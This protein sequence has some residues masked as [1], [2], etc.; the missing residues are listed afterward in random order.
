MA[1]KIKVDG[2]L[3]TFEIEFKGR[4]ETVE[5]AFNPNDLDL[6][7]RLMEAQKIIEEK[8]KNVKQFEIGEDGLP[9]ADS[10]IAYVENLNQIVYDAVD[11]AFDNEVSTAIFK[12]CSP[13]GIVN[14]EY[15]I[16]HFLQQITPV[17]EK[18]I[19]NNQKKVNENMN[20]HLAKYVKK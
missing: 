17:I 11:Y 7:K 8:S 16:Q 14:G 2:G 19:K 5:I 6:P 15:F 1:H 9:D 13:Y 10:C 4:N 18:T 3:E 20:K 12:H